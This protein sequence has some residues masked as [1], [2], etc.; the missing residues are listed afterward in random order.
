M[1]LFFIC[2]GSTWCAFVCMYVCVCVTRC[3]AFTIYRLPRLHYIILNNLSNI[4][5]LILFTILLRSIFFI[6]V[7]LLSW[8]KHSIVVVWTNLHSFVSI[9]HF[10]FYLS[11]NKMGHLFDICKKNETKRNGCKTKR[12]TY[13]C[14]HTRT[15]AKHG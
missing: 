4:F 13:T 5:V 1:F 3:R 10:S 9:G 15:Y 11:V 12:S 14:K 7:I 2:V 6:M 8:L